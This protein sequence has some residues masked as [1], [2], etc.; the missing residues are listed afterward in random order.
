MQEKRMLKIAFLGANPDH[1]GNFFDGSD[2][3]N[4]GADQTFWSLSYS[5]AWHCVTTY[6]QGEQ[7]PHDLRITGYSWG[8]WTALILANDLGADYKIRIGLID[9][10]DTLRSQQHT[11]LELLPGHHAYS[12]VP[13]GPHF[14]IKPTNVVAG[15][16]WYETTGLGGPLGG[17]FAG[18][19]ISGFE[20][21]EVS[22]PYLADDPP[23]VQICEL[24][25]KEAVAFAFYG[26]D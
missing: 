20:Q 23:H 1:Q 13:Y 3:I 26:H 24:H 25:A 14:E 19:P 15:K 10:V 2:F 8:A 16:E 7:P 9:P 17:L 18:V 11:K 4:E 21:V 5:E 12:P 22:I 6:F